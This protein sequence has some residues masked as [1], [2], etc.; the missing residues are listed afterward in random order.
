M[1]KQ[2]NQAVEYD[3]DVTP[4]ASTRS[5]P[6][7][8]IRSGALLSALTA[9]APILGRALILA[10]AVIGVCYLL[11]KVWVVVLPLILAL[12]LTSVLWPVTRFLRRAMPAAAAAAITIVALAGA[13]VGIGW[14]TAALSMNGVR[15]LS[16][17]M[18]G[19]LQNL[20]AFAESLSFS[21]AD[22]NEVLKPA[23]TWLQEN[24]GQVL[25]QVSLGLGTVGSL[26]VTFSLTLI[27]TFFCLK[28]GDRFSGWLLRWTTGTA[29]LHTA[30]VTSRSWRTLSTYISSQA[31]VALVDAVFIGIGLWLL[32]IPLALPLAVLIFFGG[33][34]PIIGAV[35][36]G[37]LASIV[38]L[39][40]EGWITAL[41]VLGLVLLVQQL[42]S[43]VLQPLL[44][45]RSLKLHPAVVLT[46]VAA[47]ASLF[48][49]EGA[50]LATP[51]I[52]VVMIAFQ[53]A[54]E[55]MLEP[56]SR[57][58]LLTTEETA[59]PASG[60]LSSVST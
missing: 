54:R 49:I 22:L 24:A 34:L 48:G 10:T 42:E 8:R 3:K 52:A 21:K 17:Q 40:T 9:I 47:G 1:S 36:T 11:S 4:A 31:A 32:G 7:R 20:G 19:N 29:L 2:Q 51:T 12:L 16:M 35:A 41:I 59:G 58:P 55:Q 18:A 44:V 37:L 28:D 46:G 56:V 39:L 33:F 53:Y 15:E 27:L 26:T 30:E 50:F 45:G 6:I 25:T 13:A 38:A 5:L 60:S 14:A 57:F 43:N 23:V